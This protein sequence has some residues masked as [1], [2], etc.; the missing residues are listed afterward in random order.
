[1]PLGWAGYT[2]ADEI[3]DFFYR[4]QAIT[5]GANLY[6]RALVSPSSRG[7]GGVETNYGGYARYTLVRGAGVLGPSLGTGARSNI[8]RVELPAATTLGNGSLVAWDVV[9][10]PS[11]DFSKVYNGGPIIP[12]IV[13]VIGKKPTAEIGMMQ[14]SF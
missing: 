9:D 4:G 14:I 1:M 11:G 2:M 5:I 7:G 13:M 10:T 3:I 12:A 6:I 8:I